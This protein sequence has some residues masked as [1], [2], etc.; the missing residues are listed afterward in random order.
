M[1]NRVLYVKLDPYD[2]KHGGRRGVSYPPL[3]VPVKS[4]RGTSTFVTPPPPVWGPPVGSQLIYTTWWHVCVVVSA[5]ESV[6]V[7]VSVSAGVSVSASVSVSVSAGVSMSASVSECECECE[8]E[9]KNGWGEETK[10]Q[11]TK[12][13]KQ[14]ANSKKQK[15][16]SKKENKK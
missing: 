5:S 16:K 14:T 15:A 2:H 4:D 10:R 9:C 1:N 12:S 7:I 6:R 3:G 8:C 13:K 11:K